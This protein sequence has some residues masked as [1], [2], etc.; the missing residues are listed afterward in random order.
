MG[1][2][3]G[4]YCIYNAAKDTWLDEYGSWI[5]HRYKIQYTIPESYQIDT[6]NKSINNRIEID[7]EVVPS[8]NNH[9]IVVEDHS[10]QGFNAEDLMLFK[11][12]KEA[13]EYIISG[14]VPAKNLNDVLSVRKIY[15]VEI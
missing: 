7:F 6:Y 13:E 4:A 11:S 9:E 15:F 14:E 12:F 3:V 1:Q 5:D 8:P 10:I 2:F